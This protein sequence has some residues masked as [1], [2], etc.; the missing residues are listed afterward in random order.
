MLRKNTKIIFN[1]QIIPKKSLKRV[2]SSEIVSRST[3]AGCAAA[4]SLRAVAKHVGQTNE[5][6]SR[7]S[8]AGKKRQ[9]RSWILGNSTR[10]RT[11]SPEYRKSR[12]C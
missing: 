1:I 8:T 7:P 4:A 11:T 10:A 12:V 5:T 3:R 2:L 6:G 9:S